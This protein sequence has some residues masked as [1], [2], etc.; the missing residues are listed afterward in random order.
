M[1]EARKN[2]WEQIHH[3]FITLYG[4]KIRPAK[5]AVKGSSAV[6]KMNSDGE[7]TIV[8]GQVI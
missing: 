8:Y 5:K 3:S 2:L 1:A 7:A 4:M 6:L